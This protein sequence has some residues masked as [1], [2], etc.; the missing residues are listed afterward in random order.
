MFAM[1]AEPAR[2]GR[3]RDKTIDDEIVRSVFELIEQ[4]G[5]GG[6]TME[7]VAERAGVSKTTV[8]R[9][10]S[11]K[12]ELLVDS[13][14]GLVGGI[15]L[16]ESDGI[17]DAMLHVITRMR[18]LM[19]NTS[20]GVVFPWLVAEVS[21]GSDIGRRYAEAVIVPGRTAI[22]A[23]LRTGVDQGELRPDLDIPLAVDMLIGPLIL[24]KLMGAYREY[25]PDFATKLVDTLLEGW[26][27]DPV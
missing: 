6:L 10:W 20:A 19:A 3:P 22:A 9:R 27:I 8:Y 15:D 24:T 4:V 23:H 17:R 21:R 5:L 25:D 18:S 1:G 12:E 14:A 13:V 11:S 7:A 2:P 16:P 26:R